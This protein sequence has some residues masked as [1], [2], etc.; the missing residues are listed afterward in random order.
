[1]AVRP[2]SDN[3]ALVE[4]W[5]HLPLLLAG[6]GFNIMGLEL[7]PSS[8]Q[9]L[10]VMNTRRSRQLDWGGH[11]RGFP[12]GDLL[13]RDTQTL[14]SLSGSF[15]VSGHLHSGSGRSP[16]NRIDNCRH[17]NQEALHKGG[18]GKTSAT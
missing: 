5:F 6:F 16:K 1:M 18:P 2:V 15:R 11:T 7:V 4:I 14:Q 12:G 9:H 3:I 17:L 8:I 10:D 13:P